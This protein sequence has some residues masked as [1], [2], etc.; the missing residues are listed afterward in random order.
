V[1]WHEADILG[2]SDFV[3]ELEPEVLI[4]LAWYAKHG[5][6]WSS[7]ENVAWVEATLALMRTFLA[8]GG[9]RAVLLGTCA[10]YEWSRELYSEDAPANPA[11]LY[12]VCKH[13]LQT[14][15]SAY[16]EQTGMSLAWAR[17]F[18]LYGPHEAP[19]RFV[20]S[21]V[22][23]LLRDEPAK[24]SAGTQR[25]DFL[26]VADAAAALVALAESPVTGTVNVASGTGVELREV[27]RRIAE[28]VGGDG[29]IEFG[30]LSSSAV[31]PP[32]LVA[33]VRRLRDE[34]GWQPGVGL[35]DGLHD[36]IEWWRRQDRE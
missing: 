14:I 29:R 16:A 28:R 6:F 30:A 15:A 23:A 24:M 3:G 36:A 25:R 27:A 20:P 21:I 9:R 8:A 26:H 13:A 22:R 10:E 35:D 7:L 1:T 11:T 19:G 34:V 4:H 2:G 32:S 18:F 5:E 12:G 17:L 31:D 33:D